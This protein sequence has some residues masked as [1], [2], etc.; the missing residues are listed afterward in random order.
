MFFLAQVFSRRRLCAKWL[1][2]WTP[3]HAVVTAA[4]FD[5]SLLCLG[6]LHEFVG[7]VDDEVGA[8]FF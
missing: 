6:D 4:S 2:Y 1:I 3:A 7:M 8:G 5:A